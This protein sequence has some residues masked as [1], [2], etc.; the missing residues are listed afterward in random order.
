MLVLKRLGSKFWEFAELYVAGVVVVDG[1]VV[2][3]GVGTGV[4][5]DDVEFAELNAFA[6]LNGFAEFNR[7]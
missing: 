5:N 7:F 6:E 1:V 2:T 4:I 3:R